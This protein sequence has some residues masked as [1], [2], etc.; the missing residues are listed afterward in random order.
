MKAAEA[1]ALAEENRNNRVSD[2]YLAIIDE[3]KKLAINGERKYETFCPLMEENI[4][5]LEKDGYKIERE[6]TLKD[7]IYEYRIQW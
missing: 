6:H 7:S 4:L 1:R 2:Q 5:S 3:I